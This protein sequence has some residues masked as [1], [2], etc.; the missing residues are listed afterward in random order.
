MSLSVGQSTLC[1]TRRVYFIFTNSLHNYIIL[2]LTDVKWN[3]DEI[4]EHGLLRTEFIADNPNI[5][6]LAL[7]CLVEERLM[8]VI[9]PQQRIVGMFQHQ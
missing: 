7:C 8:I 3:G 6:C 5:V 9:F 1:W 4:S 2:L